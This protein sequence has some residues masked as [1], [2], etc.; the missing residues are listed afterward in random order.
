M[1][2]VSPNITPL[3]DRVLLRLPDAETKT[4]SGILIPEVAQ[5]R[6]N[7]GIVVRLGHGK[8]LDGSNYKF[9]VEVGKRCI[10]QT[11]VGTPVIIKGVDHLI[12]TEDNILARE[13]IINPIKHK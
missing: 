1:T 12:I 8:M 13:I 7:V 3:M 2:E 10:Y 4:D 5:K 9:E 6:T 11:S